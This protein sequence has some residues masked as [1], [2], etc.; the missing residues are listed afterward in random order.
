MNFLLQVSLE[1]GKYIL[2]DIIDNCIIRYIEDEVALMDLLSRYYKPLLP[3]NAYVLPPEIVCKCIIDARSENVEDFR[4]KIVK[5]YYRDDMKTEFSLHKSGIAFVISEM[6]R[7]KNIVAD[8]NM[9]IKRYQRIHG[10]IDFKKGLVN[11]KEKEGLG[12][13]SF[14]WFVKQRHS[15]FM[16]DICN[17]YRATAEKSIL[18]DIDLL[19]KALV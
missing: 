2:P 5:S 14:R 9:F 8:I 11:S 4:N 13:Y 17:E 16:T 3:P 18:V 1:V 12:V 19:Q 6:E 15:N 10:D 7:V